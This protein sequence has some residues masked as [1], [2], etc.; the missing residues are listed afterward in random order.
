MTPPSRYARRTRP[1]HLRK[2]VVCV[3]LTVQMVVTGPSLPPFAS[4]AMYTAVIPWRQSTVNSL[5]S[6]HSYF[7]A[8]YCSDV[9]YKVR[10]VRSNTS[11]AVTQAHSLIS[12]FFW[13]CSGGPDRRSNGERVQQPRLDPEGS[14]SPLRRSC[15]CSCV[16]SSPSSPPSSQPQPCPWSRY[17][18]MTA[19]T[20]LQPHRCQPGFKHGLC[21]VVCREYT[22]IKSHRKVMGMDEGQLRSVHRLWVRKENSP[23]DPNTMAQYVNGFCSLPT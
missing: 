12:S 5:Y 2:H 18:I 20:P 3:A 4:D 11:T 6:D 10:Q 17:E 23:G 1:K 15:S 13:T 8:N 19:H 22:K 16:D 21:S 9:L 14:T 7:V